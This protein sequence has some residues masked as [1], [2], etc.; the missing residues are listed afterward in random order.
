MKPLTLQEAKDKGYYTYS[1]HNGDY[2]Y[3]VDKTEHLIRNGIE[4]AKGDWVFSY[5]NGD[6]KYEVYGKEHIIR[7]GK[8]IVQR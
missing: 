8:K 3:E 4:I 7:N 1:Y 2:S 6:Y 5:D